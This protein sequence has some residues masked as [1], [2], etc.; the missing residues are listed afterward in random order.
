MAMYT[1]V[2]RVGVWAI[3]HDIVWSQKLACRHDF[4]A[5]AEDIAAIYGVRVWV[6][7]LECCYGC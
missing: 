1:K 6:V 3:E 7:D 5:D 2:S 4:E